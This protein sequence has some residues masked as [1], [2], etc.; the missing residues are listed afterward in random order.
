MPRHKNKT[1]TIGATAGI[2]DL[3][4]QAA[5]RAH[6]APATM[7]ELLRDSARRAK[8]QASVTP[9]QAGEG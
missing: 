3:L 4:S 1:P 6:S 8:L 2:A 7:I 5:D 9:R